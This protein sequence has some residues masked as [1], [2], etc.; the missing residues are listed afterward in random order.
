MMKVAAIDDEETLLRT[1][2]R[3]L[4]VHG[5]SVVCFSSIQSALEARAVLATQD[6]LLVDFQL[7]D[8]NGLSLVQ[9]LRRGGID[10]PVVV[11]S[12]RANENDRIA[13]IDLDV[14]DVVQK[15]CGTAELAARLRKAARRRPRRSG[16]PRD[17]SLR[18]DQALGELTD[19]ERVARLSEQSATLFAL[20]SRSRGR[21]IHRDDIS[22]A[23]W[24][25]S[26]GEADALRF[27]DRLD[28]ALTRLRSELGPWRHIVEVRD[29]CVRVQ[30][31]VQ[32]AGSSESGARPK[33]RTPGNRDR[34]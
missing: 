4:P 24:G 5:V 3:G 26:A 9:S 33:F 13:A 31:S 2:S 28:S 16:A 32:I 23:L 21:F 8:G 29:K 20:F 7:L 17:R 12:G 18:F 11:F 25:D 27:N 1:L 15:P 19:G 22:A 30:I 10:V 34:R 14:A 6:A